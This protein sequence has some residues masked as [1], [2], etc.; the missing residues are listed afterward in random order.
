MTEGEPRSPAR[1]KFWIYSPRD[2]FPTVEWPNVNWTSPGM[3]LF[4]SMARFGKLSQMLLNFS[5]AGT[6][7]R[8]AS[9]TDPRFAFPSPLRGWLSRKADK[10]W[11]E[12]MIWIDKCYLVWSCK[13]CLKKK[14]WYSSFLFNFARSTEKVS[15]VKEQLLSFMS[16]YTYLA[17]VFSNPVGAKLS[18]WRLG[19]NSFGATGQFCAY[20]I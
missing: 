5:V 6:I 19:I 10:A 9:Y 17:L 4:V 14:S 20:G 2:L 3:D 12:I 1:A 15:R 16:L 18:R 7:A 8:I 11:E 13:L